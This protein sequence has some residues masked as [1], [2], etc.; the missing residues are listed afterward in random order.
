MAHAHAQ[1]QNAQKIIRLAEELGNE[2]EHAIADQE[3]A[4]HLAHLARFARIQ[5]QQHEQQQPFHEELVDLRRMAR[6]HGAAVRKHHAPRQI[7]RAEP[8]PQ[9]AID[10]VAHAPGSQ[11]CRHARRDEVHHLQPRPLARTRKPQLRR[12][13][14]QHAAMKAHAALPD[15][16][17]FQRMAEVVTG[18]IEQAIAQPPAHHH[19]HDAEEQDVFNVLGRPGTGAGDGRIGLVAQAQAGQKE[20]Q[21][22]GGQIRQ[23]VPVN[24][25]GPQLERNRIDFGMDEHGLPLCMQAVS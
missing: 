24:G 23:A 22:K 1:R 20:E 11:P 25:K 13:H 4:R 12:Q 19:A 15:V 5:P 3:S 17:D 14:P 21:A 2:T 6:Q 9:L 7:G 18:F 8:A 10:E 16:E